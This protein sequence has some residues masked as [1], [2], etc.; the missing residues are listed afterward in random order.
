MGGEFGNEN[1]I[2]PTDR[3]GTHPAH[4]QSSP[5]HQYRCPSQSKQGESRGA[6]VVVI[7]D[8]HIEIVG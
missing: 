4:C 5:S 2:T 1:S 8:G 7:V 3:F 6:F